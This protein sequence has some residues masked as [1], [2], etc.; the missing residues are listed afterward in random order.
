MNEAI[1][2]KQKH[3]LIMV[4]K[5]AN[6]VTSCSAEQLALNPIKEMRCFDL[7]YCGRNN[8]CL[9]NKYPSK[10]GS[11]TENQI[12]LFH[13]INILGYD[14][15]CLSCPGNN[16]ISRFQL[17]IASQDRHQS[18]PHCFSFSSIVLFGR[19]HVSVKTFFHPDTVSFLTS[20]FYS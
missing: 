19:V 4:F 18:S 10:A 6:F 14:K 13:I 3:L 7:R 9:H 11:I 8:R 1:L 16:S 20:L 2:A 15:S 12:L 5:L 17:F